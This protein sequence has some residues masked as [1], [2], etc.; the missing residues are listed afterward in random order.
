LDAN[1]APYTPG[2]NA[3]TNMVQYIDIYPTLMAISGQTLTGTLLDGINFYTNLLT[4]TPA[5]TGFNNCY[6][7]LDSDWA[8]IRSD[9][10]KLHFNR[11]LGS[12]KL[13]LYD[14]YNDIGEKINVQATTATERDTLIGLLDTW[15]ASGDVTASFMPLAGATIPPYIAPAPSGDI[16]EI[17]AVQTA[18]ISSPNSQGVYIRYAD[19][20]IQLGDYAHAGDVF[21]YDLYVAPDSTQ[22]SGIFC[23]PSIGSS[24]SFDSSH[25]I[26]TNG[27][28]ISKQ[29]WPTGKWIRVMAGMGEVAANKSYASFITL[30]G[31]SPGYYHFYIDN[32]AIHKKDGSV[33]AVCWNNVTDARTSPW[34]LRGSTTYS[35]LSAALASSGFP[36]SSISLNTVNLNTL[37]ITTLPGSNYNSWASVI[38][39]GIGTYDPSGSGPTNPWPIIMEYGLGTDPTTFT[40][41]LLPG[42]NIPTNGQL[43]TYTFQDLPVNS[44]SNTYLTMTFNFNRQANDI[45][46]VMS[47]SSNLVDW[48]DAIVLQPPYSDTST[49]YTNGQVINV[50]DNSGGNPAA[51]T[52]VTARNSI[53]LKDSAND[54]LKLSVRPVVNK[55]DVPTKLYANS[56]DG[57]LLEWTGALDNGVYLIERA[58]SGSGAYTEITR[59]ANSLYTDTTAISGQAYDYRVRAM[60]AAGLTGW[61]NV[62]TITR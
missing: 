24:P 40:A 37:P 6:F 5:R 2:D 14:L 59:T 7:G 27:T 11:V 21:V 52:R 44:Q 32:M 41:G 25:G 34:Y 35:T 43:G 20:V 31:A 15:F 58:V 61:S 23:S 13:E 49:L 56:H 55:P 22:V 12:Q 57:I 4:R 42:T 50:Q 19:P 62:A 38:G 53:A 54:F 17:K 33:R 1:T 16:L 29:V 48:V 28:N 26:A 47:E 60:N 39:G 10:W 3:Y 18:S 46:V 30:C 8:A 51:T 9:R 45:K 36:F